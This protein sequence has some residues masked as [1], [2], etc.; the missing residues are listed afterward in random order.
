MVDDIQKV[1]VQFRDGCEIE[2]A[3]GNLSESTL[4]EL[5]SSGFELNTLNAEKD[6]RYILLEWGDGWKEVLKAPGDVTKLIRYY[7]ISRPED[8]GRIVFARNDSDYP[9]LVEI[10]RKPKELKR[11]TII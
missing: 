8:S 3:P 6:A 11:V 1:I 10:Y 4:L 5:A 7:V 9:E 2:I